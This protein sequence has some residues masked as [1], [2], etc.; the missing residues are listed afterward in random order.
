MQWEGIKA[1]DKRR[2]DTANTAEVMVLPELASRYLGAWDSI[3]IY[4]YA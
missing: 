4:W 3:H 1:R 2:R